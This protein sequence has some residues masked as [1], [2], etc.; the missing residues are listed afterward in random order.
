MA[1]NIH[2]FSKT[3]C[4]DVDMDKIGIRGKRVIELAQL[5]TSILPGIIIDT[6][7]ASDLSKFKLGDTLLKFAEKAESEI[8]KKFNDP[9]NPAILKIVISPS[10][11]IVNYPSIH[12]IGLTDKTIS[13]FEKM[14]GE[15]FAYHEYAR[16]LIKGTI[17]ILVKNGEK[18]NVEKKLIDKMLFFLEKIDI[19][20][21]IDEESFQKD[22]LQKITLEEEKT[23]ISN[24]YNQDKKNKIYLVDFKVDDKKMKIL[25]DALTYLEHRTIESN[26]YEKMIRKHTKR[27]LN[28]VG[29]K[30]KEIN[31]YKELIDEART[32]LP[33][34]F[35][36]DAYFQLEYLLKQVSHFLDTE[37]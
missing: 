35:F 21:K 34:E 28:S 1:K 2:Y 12:T 32:F 36:Q 29:F 13:G 16:F 4:P 23:I 33:K 30:L 22:V 15:H 7:I 14:V 8:G 26:E 37:D 27:I 10:M 31:D 11:E 18:D 20:Q 5:K 24:V 6:E 3:E 25:L 17:D 19:A 9:A